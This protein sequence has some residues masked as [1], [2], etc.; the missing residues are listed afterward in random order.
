MFLQRKEESTSTWELDTS[1]TQLAGPSTTQADYTGY[2]FS[3]KRY[4]LLIGF[5]EAFL[6]TEPCIHDFL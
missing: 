5:T 4:T 2:T 1:Q 3:N 6:T